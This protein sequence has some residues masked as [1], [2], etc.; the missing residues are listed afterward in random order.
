LCDAF[1]FV[2]EGDEQWEANTV[3]GTSGDGSG[4]SSNESTSG[5]ELSATTTEHM[6]G[7]KLVE[8]ER[9]KYFKR[10]AVSAHYTGLASR[11]VHAHSSNRCLT[12]DLVST[13]FISSFFLVFSIVSRV[14]SGRMCN[15]AFPSRVPDLH[16]ANQR[17]TIAVF[18]FNSLK[19]TRRTGYSLFK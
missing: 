10:L 17:P 11:L 3:I 1:I 2:L 18:Y 12:M 19:L 5:N 16:F 4:V 9:L 13:Y 6:N 8:A 7:N 14:C 15:Y